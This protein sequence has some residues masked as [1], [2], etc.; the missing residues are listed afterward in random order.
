MYR[1]DVTDGTGKYVFEDVQP[2][3]YDI[4]EVLW[5]DWAATT[6][7][8][9]HVSVTGSMVYFDIWVNIGNMEYAT[10]FG[11]KFLDTYGD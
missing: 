8:P 3:V 2:G 5:P 10:V 9:V 1:T 6:P 7:L 4:S 11:Y